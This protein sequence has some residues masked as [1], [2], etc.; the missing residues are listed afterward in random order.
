MFITVYDVILLMLLD[1]ETNK[2]RKKL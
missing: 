2:E 1:S